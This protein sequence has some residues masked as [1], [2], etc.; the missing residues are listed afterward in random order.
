MTVLSEPPQYW[1]YWNIG[2]IKYQDINL[3]DPLLQAPTVYG[4]RDFCFVIRP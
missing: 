2:K 4:R 1:V 3:G